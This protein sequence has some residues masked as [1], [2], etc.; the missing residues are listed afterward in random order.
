MKILLV[1]AI[2]DFP[3][4]GGANRTYRL[5]L[6]ALTRKGHTCRLLAPATD[7]SATRRSREDSTS[8]MVAAGAPL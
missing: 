1:Q 8:A 3:G 7:G 6:E 2:N 4:V 5:L